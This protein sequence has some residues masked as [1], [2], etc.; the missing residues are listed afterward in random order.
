MAKPAPR[1]V[2]AKAGNAGAHPAA[3]LSAIPAMTE[4]QRS[5]VEVV[6]PPEQVVM[7]SVRIPE[8]L[9]KAV[10]LAAVADGV[11]IETWTEAALKSTLDK[12]A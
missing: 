3:P 6:A 9:R 12:Q 10:K 7:F 5:A 2:L 11:T 8:S 1:P 4:S